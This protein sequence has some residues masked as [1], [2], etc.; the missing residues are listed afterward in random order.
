MFESI[1]DPGVITSAQIVRD[2]ESR[3]FNMH[4]VYRQKFLQKAGVPVISVYPYGRGG[5]CFVRESDWISKRDLIIGQD[6]LGMPIMQEALKIKKQKVFK[7]K[8]INKKEARALQLDHTAM[9]EKKLD[10]ISW[11]LSEMIKLEVKYG[12]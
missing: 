1:C 3:G 12:A 2:L 10:L 8:K 5:V 6:S 7:S 11:V 4:G 9:I